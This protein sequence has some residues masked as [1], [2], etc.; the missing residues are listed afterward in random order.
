MPPARLLGKNSKVYLTSYG[1]DGVLESATR[2]ELTAALRG[3]D[4][5]DLGEVEDLVEISGGGDQIGQQRAGYAE[6]TSSFVVD[7]NDETRNLCFAG[8]NRKFKLE[9]YPEGDANGME[10]LTVDGFATTL[11][12]E[13]AERGKV[14]FNFSQFDHDGLIT[15][16]VKA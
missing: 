15:V 10:E 16:G 5:I 13:H 4:G 1:F 6:G 3:F 9:V 8:F 7:D 2:T 12:H 14:R 11:T